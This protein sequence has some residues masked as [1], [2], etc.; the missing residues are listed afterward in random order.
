VILSSR[1]RWGSIAL[2]VIGLSGCGHS[3]SSSSPSAYHAPARQRP[4]LPDSLSPRGCSSSTMG[5]GLLAVCDP[6]LLEQEW[7]NHTLD[8]PTTLDVQIAGR[9]VRVGAVRA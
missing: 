9:K 3:S 8:E 5:G 7:T 1:I 2:L 6:V 4:V